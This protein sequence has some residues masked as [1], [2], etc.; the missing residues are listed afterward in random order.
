MKK[1]KEMQQ[2]LYPISCYLVK[3]IDKKNIIQKKT[4]IKNLIKKIVDIHTQDLSTY[5]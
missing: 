3:K 2:K 1:N 5:E 4:D